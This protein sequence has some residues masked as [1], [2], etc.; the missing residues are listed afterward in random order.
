[1]SKGKTSAERKARHRAWEQRH[2]GSNGYNPNARV[3]E[4]PYNAI[5]RGDVGP[6][7]VVDVS[8][9]T[10]DFGINR[11]N[12]IAMVSGNGSPEYFTAQVRQFNRTTRFNLGERVDYNGQQG[13][14]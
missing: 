9:A 1:M 7:N 4:V 11:G 6:G 10:M 14:V 13:S 3:I 5:S 2:N 8:R 12:V